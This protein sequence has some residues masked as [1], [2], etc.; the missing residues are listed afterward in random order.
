MLIWPG[1]D[2]AGVDSDLVLVPVG[3]FRDLIDGSDLIYWRSVFV[4]LMKPC[5]RQL[6][7]R[8]TFSWSFKKRSSINKLCAFWWFTV[9]IFSSE[10]CWCSTGILLL[11]VCFFFFPYCRV[12][13]VIY[14]VRSFCLFLL[15]NLLAFCDLQGIFKG[16]FCLNDRRIKEMSALRDTLLVQI[17]SGV[18]RLVSGANSCVS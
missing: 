17:Q 4:S 12:F 15:R 1:L 13:C 8:L 11:F 6:M 10:G 5:R 14:L 9:L 2:E 18:L 16:K 7:C 3:S